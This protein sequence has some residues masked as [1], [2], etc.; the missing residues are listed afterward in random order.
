MKFFKQLFC[1][2]EWLQVG[3]GMSI[4][5]PKELFPFNNFDFMSLDWLECVKCGKQ[6]MESH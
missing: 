5:G 1:K 6:K 2:H 4:P 3:R